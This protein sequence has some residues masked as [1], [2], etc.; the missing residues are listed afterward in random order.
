MVIDVVACKR[1]IN[2]IKAKILAQE[3][4]DK[5]L[6]K[7]YNYP[8]YHTILLNDEDLWSKADQLA[9]SEN[10]RLLGI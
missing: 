5:A 6:Y 1:Y 4:H 8:I 3:N 10:S 7:A 9:C 2:H